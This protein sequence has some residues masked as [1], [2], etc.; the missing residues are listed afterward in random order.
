MQPQN[1]AERRVAVAAAEGREVN[2]AGLAEGERVVRGAFLAALLWGEATDGDGRSVTVHRRRLSVRHARISGR[3]DIRGLGAIDGPA[4]ALSLTH[5]TGADGEEGFV[6]IASDASLVRLDL[7][8]STLDRI[9]ADVLRTVGD[10]RLERTTVRAGLVLRRAHIGGLLTLNGAALGASPEGVALGADGARIES[11]VFLRPVGCHRFEAQGTVRL[12]RATS[13]GCLVLCG[14]SRRHP[15]RSV[16]SGPSP[17]ALDATGA[18]VNG[19][20]DLCP[21]PK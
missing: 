12:P 17:V 1:E 10:V 5:C 6:L 16:A 19:S 7:S 14:A 15:L 21:S 11:A 20:V 9:E 3:V 4:P 2:L 13:E 8:H 18:T